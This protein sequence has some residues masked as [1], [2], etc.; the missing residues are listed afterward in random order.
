M[1]SW[2]RNQISDHGLMPASALLWRAGWAQTRARL[3][4]KLLAAR[5]ECPCCGWRGRRFYD[6][7]ETGYRAVNVECPQCASHGRHRLLKV[8]LDKEFGLAEKSGTGL[9]FA[10]EKAL[11]EVW[12]MARGWRLYKLDIIAARGVD[13]L[14]DVQRLPFK[15]DAFDLLWCHHV[16]EQTPDDQ[17]SMRELR[18]VLRPQG[19]LIISAGLSPNAETREFGFSDKRFSGNHRSYGQDFPQRLTDAGFTVENAGQGVQE[20]ERQRYGIS[21][22]ER[23]FRCRKSN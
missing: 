10:P 11:A 2:Y 22:D 13:V 8:W 14:G 23:F 17:A 19:E 5:Y 21:G 1:L 16:L 18:R 6:Y 12:E 7:L 9:I 4:N 15:D 20:A 3:A